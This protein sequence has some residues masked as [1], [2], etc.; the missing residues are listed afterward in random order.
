MLL[1]VAI[2]GC[3]VVIRAYSIWDNG[4]CLCVLKY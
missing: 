1:H 3:M 4:D 2:E